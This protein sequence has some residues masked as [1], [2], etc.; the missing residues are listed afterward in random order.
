MQSAATAFAWEFRQRHRRGALAVL[1][2]FVALAVIRLA[3]AGAGRIVFEDVETFA[4]ALVVPMVATFLYFLAIFSFGLAGDIAARQSIF[5]ARMFTLPVTSSALAGWPM[6]YGSLAMMILWLATRLLG[7]WPAGVNVPIFWPFL[8]GPSLLA[9]TQALTW[10]AYPMP[11]LRVIVTVLWLATI[12]AIVMIALELKASEGVMLALLAPHVPLAFLVAR[13]AV[14]RARRGEVPD[15]RQLFAWMGRLAN[16]VTRRR[17]SFASSARAQEWFEWR[18]YGRSLPLLVALLLPF[19]LALLFPFHQTPVIVF[20]TLCGVL[21][22]PPLM[23]FFVATTVSKS[24]SQAGDAYG[25]TPLIATRPMTTASLIAAKLKVTIQ[26][27]LIAWLLVLLAIPMA[28]RWSG[29]TTLVND[30]MR[31]LVKAI[32]MPRAIAIVALGLALLI[33]STWKQLVQSLF[34]GM[35]GREWLIKTM[36]IGAM[37]LLGVIV[38]VAH[39][40]LGKVVIEARLWVALPSILSTL[41]V[42]KLMA[43]AYV[44]IRLHHRGLVSDRTILAGAVCWDVAVFAL[45][46][47]LVW[48]TPALV[49]RRAPLALLAILAVPLARVA[50]APLALAW[51]RHR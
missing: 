15:W 8:L 1:A 13:G 31:E 45:Y 20:E 23:A 28:L 33:S 3:V 34:I 19:E 36:A 7:T 26:S 16:V 30:W 42:L 14:A 18:Q 2:S 5:P 49:F 25:V 24:S 51:N 9:W 22:T 44:A 39:W 4:I 27:T 21:L 50:A 43:A 38:P 47:L 12:D 10:M 48:L 40:A 11:G 17:D 29:A 46:G 41:V 32:G 6:L 37:T 35:T